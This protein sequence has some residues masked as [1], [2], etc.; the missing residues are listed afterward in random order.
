M[1]AFR[2]TAL[3]HL[4][5]ITE[6]MLSR[7]ML[8]DEGGMLSI[9]VEEERAFGRR[10]FMEDGFSTPLSHGAPCLVAQAPAI[11]LSS[12]SRTRGGRA[13]IESMR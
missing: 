13:A 1:P 7:G 6:F 3:E 11:S 8:C 5:G 2:V 10:H 4:D 12:G 9:G